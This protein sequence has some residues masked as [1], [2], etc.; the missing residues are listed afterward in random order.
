[1]LIAIMAQIRVQGV[2]V[3]VLAV[4]GLELGFGRVIQIGAQSAH[5]L[6]AIPLLAL[7]IL[8]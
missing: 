2:D 5:Q 1:M 6:R 4:S 7:T 3:G 8:G